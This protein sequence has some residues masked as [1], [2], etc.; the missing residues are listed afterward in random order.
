MR[1]FDREPRDDEDR[2]PVRVHY[3]EVLG[4]DE[5]DITAQEAEERRQEAM[6]AFIHTLD[7]EAQRR[8]DRR[9]PV[10]RRW[11][12]DLR[13]YQGIYDDDTQARIKE[14][15]G[16]EAFINLTAPKTEALAARL[17]DL[18]FPTDDRNWGVSPTPVPELTDQAEA[19][20]KK[21]DDARQRADLAALEMEQAATAA[22]AQGTDPM[23]DPRALEAEGQMREA[24]EEETIAQAAA[25]DLH[26]VLQEA[27]RRADLMAEEIEDQLQTCSYPSEARDMIEDACKIGIGVIKGPVL[28]ERMKQRWR[29]GEGGHEL[30]TESDT[31]PAAYRI[32]PWTF[33]PDPDCAKPEDGEGVFERHILSKKKLR[34]LAQRDGMNQDAIRDL[35]KIG[36]KDRAP[37]FMNDL[38]LMTGQSNGD[39]LDH[40]TVWEYTGPIEPDD[41]QMLA[42]DM[43]RPETIEA[44][45]ELDILQEVNAKVWFCDGRVLNFALHPLDSGETVYSVFTIRRDE[46]GPFGFGVPWI[47]AHPQAVLNG[48]YRMMLD[49]SGL[50]TGPQII[51]DKDAVEPQDGDWTVKPR[52]VWLYTDSGLQSTRKPLDTFD[53]PNRQNEL[54]GIVQLASQTID[55][56]TAMPA[57][58]QGEQGTGVT[59]T[60]QGMALL[61]NSAN[62]TFRRIVKNFD[63]D[64]SVPL[65]RRLYHWNMQFSPKEEIK[66]DYDTVARGSSVLLVREMQAQNLLMIAQAFGDHPIFGP[67]LKHGALLRQI[68]KAHMLSGDE[69]MRSDR[70]LEEYLK[71][72]AEKQGGDPAAAAQESANAIA[73]EEIA[74]RKAEMEQKGELA[75]MEWAKRE[76]IAKLN[77]DAT[78]AK[79]AE[80]L[81]MKRDE[82]DAKLGIEREKID[83]SERKLAVEA[84]T[85]ERTGDSAGGSI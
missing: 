56:V 8:V 78:M 32:D 11:L 46:I 1:D 48:A 24:E 50:S 75:N 61:M 29:A 44:L 83:S 37:W 33:F 55:E 21:A 59:K 41:L 62:V 30:K 38:A 14:N 64:V 79:V 51:M 47:M 22:Q 63:D 23:Q 85:K 60:A 36:P 3:G 45:G 40:F 16:S 80:A 74:L 58:A 17:I 18:L 68:F 67:M 6:R 2:A 4:P 26:K 77:Y 66:G 19:E 72:Q 20:L 25:E 54:A 12:T 70:E 65:I 27:H 71:E 5:D 35:L 9:E 28:G 31:M 73:R 82:L 69:V 49:N 7:R 10:E 42:E 57:V 39:L 15:G 34:R 84:A 81:N 76:A 13:Q 52:K 43:G 53:I